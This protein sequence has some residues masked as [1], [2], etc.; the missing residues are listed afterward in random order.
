MYHKDSDPNLEDRTPKSLEQRVSEAGL[1]GLKGLKEFL[2][3]KTHTVRLKAAQ[4]LKETPDRGP[5]DEVIAKVVGFAV[6]K[7][8]DYRLIDKVNLIG[9][10]TLLDDVQADILLK[11][12]I[13]DD[14]DSRIGLA[15][16]FIEEIERIGTACFDRG[17]EADRLKAFLESEEVLN[18]LVSEVLHRED[19][20]YRG[21]NLKAI[22]GSVVDTLIRKI[23]NRIGRA[24]KHPVNKE[25]E[26]ELM[27]RI[28]Y[29]ENDFDPRDKTHTVSNFITHLEKD[30]EEYDV[31]GWL[32]K[33]KHLLV[34]ITRGRAEE[35]YDFRKSDNSKRHVGDVID[36]VYIRRGQL[37]PEQFINLHIDSF[38]QIYDDDKKEEIPTFIA[39]VLGI[40]K[41]TVTGLVVVD[42]DSM[43]DFFDRVMVK[44]QVGDQG[45]IQLR[46]KLIQTCLKRMERSKTPINKIIFISNGAPISEDFETTPEAGDNLAQ[47]IIDH[48]RI[49]ASHVDVRNL[50][51]DPKAIP[52]EIAK[53]YEDWFDGD[54]EFKERAY[55]KYIRSVFGQMVA[56]DDAAS[57]FTP[58]NF[59]KLRA[60]VEELFDAAMMYLG[61]VSLGL[62]IPD[63]HVASIREV[64][65]YADLVK[66]CCTSEDPQERFAARRKIELAFLIYSCLITPRYVYQDYEAKAVKSVLEVKGDLEIIKDEEMVL[67]F[68]DHKNGRIT[69]VSNN[70]DDEIAKHPDVDLKSVNLI[71]ANFAGIKCGLLPANGEPYDYMSKKTLNSMVTNLLNEENKRAKDMT[72]LLRM[73]F[74]VDSMEDLVHV[75]QHLETN[76]ISFGRSLKREDRYAKTA[77]KY[78]V[79][80]SNNQA[81]ASDYKTLRYVVDVVIP[82]EN[83][84]K[85]PKGKVPTY[86]VPVEI[87]VLLR[88]D[89]MKEK[90]DNHPASHK[91][92]EEKR[93]NLAVPTLAPK[94]V[95]PGHYLEES[96]N[97]NDVFKRKQTRLRKKDELKKAT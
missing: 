12:D 88:E 54:G 86:A 61:S 93:L 21:G 73:T 24:Q 17:I 50:L 44:L 26:K 35:K 9:T 58:E 5:V 38:F 80:V 30:F 75:Q 8:K 74:V 52:P 83:V 1:N 40:N 72:D 63:I 55:Y 28:E 20:V 32:S 46:E 69:D 19:S 39:K 71:P 78:Q 15:A 67:K 87:R 6:E 14:L 53:N 76:Y 3:T 49:V 91:K 96:P 64:N 45:L 37:N 23:E 2:E 95:F 16:P 51:S 60:R 89:V 36:E 10:P 65:D 66:I 25:L 94:E 90:S 82:D 43:A 92:Y 29:F 56:K 42:L 48:C 22:A 79:A 97:P 59:K 27:K 7:G 47:K 57:K 41:S 77:S 33:N 31:F 85:Y 62:N 84:D 68:L 81:K 70:G 34:Q 11:S 4:V 13:V 18:F